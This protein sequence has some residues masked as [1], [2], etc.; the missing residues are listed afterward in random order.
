[1]RYI[2]KGKCKKT[3]TS[4]MWNQM[5]PQGISGAPG[6]NGANGATGS[7][8]RNLRVIDAN[9]QDMGLLISHEQQELTVLLGGRIWDFSIYSNRASGNLNSNEGFYSDSGCTQELVV[10]TVAQIPTQS[11]LNMGAKA[12]SVSTV[13]P[14]S[15]QARIYSTSTG[16]CTRLS[17]SQISSFESDGFRIGEVTEIQPPTYTAPLTIVEK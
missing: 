4:L 9:G 16:P 3:E 11:V 8:G 15:S 1:M 10:V 17:T 7:S 6:A 13:R 12:W 2:A 5:G 14:L